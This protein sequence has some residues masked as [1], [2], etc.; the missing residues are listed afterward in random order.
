MKKLKAISIL[1]LSFFYFNASYSQLN[2]EEFYDNKDELLIY[3]VVSELEVESP[4]E[5]IELLKQ[6]GGV[7]FRNMKEVLTSETSDQLVFNY[8]TESFTI[9]TLGKT[10]AYG[11]N[12][13]MVAQIKDGKVRLQFFDDG[14]SFWS[15]TVTGGA[16]IPSTP[17]RSYRFT[18]YFD[19][20]GLCKKPHYDGL[21]N[22]R[23][24]CIDKSVEIIT[25]INNKG[26]STIE[27]GDG[28]W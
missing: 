10:N 24:S 27:D 3:S 16:T 25:F 2:I 18:S 15:G 12:I 11:W 17:S 20:K 5:I 28:D 7:N 6:W 23:K 14:N 9:K 19:K 13:R 4:E 22:V 26:N 1:L 8:I 21:V